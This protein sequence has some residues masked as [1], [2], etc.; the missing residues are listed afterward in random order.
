MRKN[1][2]YQKNLNI[3]H[4]TTENKSGVISITNKAREYNSNI[5]VYQEHFINDRFNYTV[6]LDNGRIEIPR[7]MAQDYEVQP[8]SVSE[9][10]IKRV[11]QTYMNQ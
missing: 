5:G 7:E 9:E 1:F 2:G 11:A 8:S 3:M 6:R 4:K 10:R